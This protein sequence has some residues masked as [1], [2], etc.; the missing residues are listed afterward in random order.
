MNDIWQNHS[1]SAKLLITHTS[2]TGYQSPP[3][4]LREAMDFWEMSIIFCLSYWWDCT[5]SP[6]AF[7]LLA[8][9][10]LLVKCPSG[11]FHELT[12]ILSSLITAILFCDTGELKHTFYFS[13]SLMQ[14][15]GKSMRILYNTLEIMFMFNN[16]SFSLSAGGH[17][18]RVWWAGIFWTLL[19]WDIRSPVFPSCKLGHCLPAFLWSAWPQALH[20]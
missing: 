12:H 5:W 11:A 13:T 10:A 20:I 17:L 14:N 2:F 19:Q 6:A 18:S 16:S 9:V 1:F 3:Q 8:E 4:S 7:L 15:L